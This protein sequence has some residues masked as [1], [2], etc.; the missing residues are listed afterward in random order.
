[1]VGRIT[2]K[3][4]KTK[5][6]TS[7]GTVP[8]EQSQGAEERKPGS[9]PAT[10]GTE[11]VAG[12]LSHTASG[13]DSSSTRSARWVGARDCLGSGPQLDLHDRLEIFQLHDGAKVVLIQWKAA[14]QTYDV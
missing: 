13:S 11:Y 9:P 1:M 14:R 8:S 4:P 12:P 7:L 3:G 2:D 10:S 6:E 5:W